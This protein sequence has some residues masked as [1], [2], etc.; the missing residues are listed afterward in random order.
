[1]EYLLSVVIPTKNRYKYLEHLINYVTGFETNLIE[2]VIQDNTPDNK[3]ILEF[4]SGIKNINLKYFHNKDSMP[5]S[6]NSDLAILNSTGEYVCFIGDDD[7]VLPQIVEQVSEMKRLGY[8]AMLT[9]GAVYNWPDYKDNSYFHMSATLAVDAPHGSNYILKTS[10][11]VIN[12]INTGFLNMGRLPKVYQ[13]VIK[14]VAL[15]IVYSKCGTYFPGPSPDMA[16]AIAL[17]A[18]IDEVWYNDKAT[19][20]T[21]QSRCIGGGERL[22]NELVQITERPAIAKNILD[23][24]DSKLPTYWCTDTIWPGSAYIAANKMGMK[25]NLDYNKI[26]ARFMFHHPK[27]KNS[28]SSYEHNNILVAYFRYRLFFK[29]SIKWFLNRLSYIISQK[30]RIQSQYIIRD[31][32]TIADA[33]EYLQTLF[34]KQSLK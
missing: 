27:Y 25:I 21:G 8:Q 22:L 14:R 9:R 10:Q 16:N 7:G 5:I 34:I 13:G 28:I 3:E 18:V 32:E 24:W 26:Y 20:I 23:Y 33:S 17:C 12:V 1:M 19:I 11:E 4:L 2:F 31:L 29:Q 15:D 6:K 30:N